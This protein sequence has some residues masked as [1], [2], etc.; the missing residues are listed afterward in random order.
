MT[1]LRDLFRGTLGHERPEADVVN[2][3]ARAL[4]GA[5]VPVVAGEDGWL[6]ALAE[7]AADK[8]FVLLGEATHG[9]HEFYELRSA[10]SRRLI[11]AHGFAGIVCEADWPDMTRV[12]RFLQ[13][14]GEDAAPRAALDAFK[15][16]PRW[17]W[18]NEVV[19]DLVGQLR[20]HNDALPA[21]AAKAGM[22]GM[23]LYSLYESQSAVLAYMDGVDPAA[24]ARARERYGCFAPFG[25]DPQAY[26]AAAA[27]GGPIDSH[28][29]DCEDEA[30]DQLVELMRRR[31]EYA[32]RDGQAAEEEQFFAEQNARLI[33]SAERYYREL[34]RGGAST[35]NLRDTHMADT[36]DALAAH[37]TARRG[38]PAK[39]IVW[40]HNSHLGDARYTDMGE[41]RDE[42]NVGQL[43]RERHGADVFILGFTTHAGTVTA[44]DDWDRPPRRMRVTPSRADSLEQVLH[45][46]AYDSEY[47]AGGPPD[48]PA[49]LL[50][51]PP[52]SDAAGVLEAERLQRAIG[53]IY[54]PATE[55]RSH[56]FA[57]RAGRQFDALIHV[58]VTTALQPLDAAAG[59]A[60]GPAE[61]ET[62]PTGL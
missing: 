15:R 38:A 52:G 2:D 50:M 41:A 17:M 22:W 58:D 35:W 46:A 25:G 19:L 37:L 10:L 13:G 16:F 3:D 31:G 20:A 7:V 57:C 6:D 23:D 30:V 34:Y 9:T 39:L 42:V 8:R 44:A 1:T 56:Y 48:R 59:F 28:G 26:G 55:R 21:G 27:L 43:L 51:P 4:R 24:A 18:R 33:A 12:H 49:Y 40:A 61:P 29:R 62:Y 47:A 36:L 53:V 5:A 11:A 14:R 54:R 32:R 45:R 60:G